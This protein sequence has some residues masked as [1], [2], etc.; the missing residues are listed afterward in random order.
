MGSMDSPNLPVRNKAG[1][2]YLDHLGLAK[3]QEDD[4][5]QVF[6]HFRFFG[7]CRHESFRVVDKNS[8]VASLCFLSV[9]TRVRSCVGIRGI[10][11]NW[12]EPFLL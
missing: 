7:H 4:P 8:S 11:S 1:V 2:D 12:L 5:V 9:S 6:L 10:Q 3:N